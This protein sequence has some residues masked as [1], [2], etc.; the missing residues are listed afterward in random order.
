MALKSKK[1]KIEGCHNPVW[2]KSKCKNHQENKK[3][4]STYTP[5]K[6]GYINKKDGDRVKMLYFFD[7]IWKSMKK[8][9]K[10]QSCSKEIYSDTNLSI[11]HHHILPKSKYPQFKFDKRNIL[12]VCP[13]CHE[14]IENGKIKKREQKII[15]KVKKELL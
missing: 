6:K 14:E 5:L 7:T 2:A 13:E 11:Y 9:R 12:F 1:C 3:G 10:C 8:P 4:L 15:D